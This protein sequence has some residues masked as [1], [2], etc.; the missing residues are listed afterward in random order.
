MNRAIISSFFADYYQSQND[1]YRCLFPYWLK[2]IVK[3]AG[4]FDKLYLIDSGFIFNNKEKALL[5]ELL[6]PDKW[7]IESALTQSHWDNMN[8]YVKEVNAKNIMILDSDTIIYSPKVI[9]SLFTSQEITKLGGL[10]IFD[11]SGQFELGV[12]S[13][14]DKT[15]ERGKRHRMCPY[16]CILNRDAYF[17]TGMNFNPR[18]L[19]EGFK[20]PKLR[21]EAK[22]GDFTDSMGLVTLEMIANG[23][24]LGEIPDDRR[25]LYLNDDGK[26]TWENNLDAPELKSNLGYYH[27]RNFHG[28]LDLVNTF[29]ASGSGRY[30]E[31]KSLIP[32]REALRLLGWLEQMLPESTYQVVAN[33][34]VD[35]D[36]EWLKYLWEMPDYHTWLNDY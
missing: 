26:I 17:R 19:N 27:I 9:D 23:D 29:G 16:L 20:I 1:R 22:T 13:V 34:G 7:Q 12:P 33:L 6:G 28:G 15:N 32:R 11:S 36:K 10:G 25:S 4:H 31:L 35:I 24:L 2:G 3:N 8:T 14:F 30:Q 18:E 5:N 21:Y